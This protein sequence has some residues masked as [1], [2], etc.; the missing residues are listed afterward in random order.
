MVVA[1]CQF[2]RFHLFLYY[3][4][5]A[6]DTLEFCVPS[7]GGQIDALFNGITITR[8]SSWSLPVNR[9]AVTGNPTGVWTF[10]RQ[11]IEDPVPYGYPA[12]FVDPYNIGGFF[13]YP[14]STPEAADPGT[15]AFGRNGSGYEF[16]SKN[17][18]DYPILRFTAPE[19]GLYAIDPITFSRDGWDPSDDASIHIAKNGVEI[20]ESDAIGNDGSGVFTPNIV[21]LDAGDTLEFCAVPVGDEL[22]ML[23]DNIT[24]SWVESAWSFPASFEAV[25]G[26]PTG[27]W[28]FLRGTIGSPTM[29]PDGEKTNQYGSY[30]RSSNTAVGRN[31]GS[32]TYELWS[33]GPDAYPIIRF[34]A[35]TSGL[36]LIDPITYQRKNGWDGGMNAAFILAKNGTPIAESAALAG[37]DHSTSFEPQPV[38]LLAGDTLEFYVPSGGDSVDALF[39]DIR[40]TLTAGRAP[41]IITPGSAMVGFGSQAIDLERIT[42]L[43]SV[44]LGAGARLYT[45]EA[46]TTGEG[47]ISGGH[48]LTATKAGVFKIGL[49]TE[50][51][52]THS[53]GA[54]AVATLTVT[55][56]PIFDRYNPHKTGG[57]WL[58]PD[59]Q[60]TTHTLD[61][62]T[63]AF[64]KTTGDLIG[65]DNGD[66][67]LNLDAG[68]VDV[69]L[70][71]S[72]TSLSSGSWARKT[73]GWQNYDALAPYDIP[74]ITGYNPTALEASPP[75][76]TIVNA[77]GAVTVTNEMGAARIAT[78][79]RVVNGNVEISATVTNTAPGKMTLNGMIC[80]A[81][82]VL[83]KFKSTVPP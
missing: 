13:R 18:T 57:L 25:T 80:G 36:Y 28:S 62:V 48:L 63:L 59:D 39:D 49:T 24:V 7:A 15:D 34:T 42:D 26:N 27:Q 6:G 20:Q 79:Y 82:I 32:G 19:T 43:F 45:I 12:D 47:T 31:S 23:F 53:A 33:G 9:A 50:E 61:G 46:G 64:N 38:A 56:E 30:Y 81:F 41:V 74:S 78:T 68:F 75:S 3:N 54:K 29:Y 44:P 70:S 72:A 10:L 37:G 55:A 71:A 73:L 51:T 16:Y 66:F 69:G 8:E 77:G 65:V 52:G 83:S 40:I 5:A 4:L 76:G 58:L 11:S 17:G 22:D 14:P 67:R 35:Q 1:D 60:V 21:Q 2:H